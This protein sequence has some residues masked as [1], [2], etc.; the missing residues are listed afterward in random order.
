[1][2]VALGIVGEQSWTRDEIIKAPKEEKNKKRKKLPIEEKESYRW[3]KGLKVAQ[4]TAQSCPETMCVCMG[5][6]EADI[7]ELFAAHAD[8]QTPNLQLLVR[9]G[10]SRSTTEKQDWVELVRGLPKVGDQTVNVRART[11]KVG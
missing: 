2:G 9:G 6:S 4:V 8:C 10:Q 11:A 7:Y 1:R 3:I 5:D